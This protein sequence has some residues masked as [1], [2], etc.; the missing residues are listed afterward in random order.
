VVTSYWTAIKPKGMA[1]T[2]ASAC[3]STLAMPQGLDFAAARLVHVHTN[4]NDGG[5][6]PKGPTG[7]GTG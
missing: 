3:R 2:S 7:D 1:G 4:G 5:W 6:R